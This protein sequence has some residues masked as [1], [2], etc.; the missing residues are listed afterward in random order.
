[1]SLFR[2]LSLCFPAVV[3]LATTHWPTR[4]DPHISLIFF[5]RTAHAGQ[6]KTD[7]PLLPHD[8]P[9]PLQDRRGSTRPGLTHAFSSCLRARPVEFKN[10][11]TKEEGVTITRFQTTAERE[12][13]HEKIIVASWT[14]GSTALSGSGPIIEHPRQKSELFFR[15][16]FLHVSFFTPH[17]PNLCILTQLTLLHSLLKPPRHHLS[18]PRPTLELS[19]LH[20]PLI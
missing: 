10:V 6:R 18:P 8:P 7:R 1:M 14:I 12:V 16:Q 3:V 15:S 9:R 19:H 17:L 20:H 11:Q 13:G 5:R 4:T 2:S